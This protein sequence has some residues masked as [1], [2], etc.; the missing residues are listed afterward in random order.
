MNME[1]MGPDTE[2]KDNQLWSDYSDRRLSL[3]F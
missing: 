3:D 2:G 1:K